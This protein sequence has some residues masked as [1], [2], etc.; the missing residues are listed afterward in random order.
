MCRKPM[1]SVNSALAKTEPS[2]L[3]LLGYDLR[4]DL[5][6][7]RYVNILFDSVLTSNTEQTGPLSPLFIL[8]DNVNA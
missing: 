7:L 1:K 3:V 6:F 2:G 8:Y 4:L 5:D